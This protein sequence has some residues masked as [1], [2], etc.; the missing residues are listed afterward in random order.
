MNHAP[1]RLL[2]AVQGAVQPTD[3]IRM[4][5]VDEAGGLAAVDSLR[6]SAVKALLTSS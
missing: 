6:Q 3:Q 5:S 2:E 1:Q 4:S